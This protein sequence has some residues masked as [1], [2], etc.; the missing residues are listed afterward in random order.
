V[1][2]CGA[3]APHAAKAA[4]GFRFAAPLA[5]ALAGCATPPTLVSESP[6]PVGLTTG[7]GGLYAFGQLI[8]QAGTSAPFPLLVDTGTILTTHAVPAPASA[9]VLRRQIRL[10]AVTPGGATGAARADFYD[11]PILDTPLASAGTAGAQFDLSGGAILGGDLLQRFSLALDYGAGGPAVSLLPA[12]LDCSC[13]VADSCRATFPFTLAGGGTLTL[14]SEVIS[15]PPTRVTLDACLEPY[16]DPLAANQPCLQSNALA[17][18]YAVD[19]RPGVD[20]R[21]LLATGFQ[22]LLLGASAWDR[23]HGPGAAAAL[24]G[25]PTEK[26]YFPGR[27]DPI[28]AASARL[29]AT[30]QRAA[31]ALVDRLGLLGPCAELNRSRRLRIWQATRPDNF[32]P[33]CPEGS[34]FG[35]AHNE[36]PQEGAATC[37]QCL[38]GQSCID[39]RGIDRCSDRNQPAASFIEIDDEFPVWVVDDAAPI[40]QEI[41]FDVAPKLSAVEGIAGTTLLSRLAARIDYPGSRVLAACAPAATGCATYPRFTCPT[42]PDSGDCGIRGQDSSAL[43]NPPSALPVSAGA[44]GGMPACLPAPR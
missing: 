9:A 32:G 15:Y 16:P 8:D 42:G 43:C 28:P 30:G 14:G 11:V 38:K 10:L 1:G 4:A 39:A 21:L 41:N 13:A 26:L 31:L 19:G 7:S 34:L 24:L 18:A 23:L 36:C 37:L 33:K 40:L 6:I 20:V 12:D 17:P 27:A 29:G 5:L 44:D 2:A 3:N 22:G 35:S 25:T